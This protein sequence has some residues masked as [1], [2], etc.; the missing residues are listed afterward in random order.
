[1]KK[2]TAKNSNLKGGN[3]VKEETLSP[4]YIGF[5]SAKNFKRPKDIKQDELKR[6]LHKKI[7]AFQESRSCKVKKNIRNEG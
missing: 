2:Y 4:S 3:V 6:L 1:M 7:N 5:Y